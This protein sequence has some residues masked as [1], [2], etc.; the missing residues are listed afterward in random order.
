MFLIHGAEI[1]HEEMGQ[2]P[3]KAIKPTPPGSH[4]AE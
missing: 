4:L 1:S 2:R 3:T